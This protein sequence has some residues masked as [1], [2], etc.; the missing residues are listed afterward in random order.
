MYSI[1]KEGCDYQDA[2]TTILK[3]EKKLGFHDGDLVSPY[4]K[5]KINELNNKCKYLLSLRYLFIIYFLILMIIGIIG[6][7]LF[8]VVQYDLS[9]I[10]LK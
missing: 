10:A 2:V 7:F 9:Y 8:L 1:Y 5:N 6:I 3:I 4:R